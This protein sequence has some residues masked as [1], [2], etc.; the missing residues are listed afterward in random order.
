MNEQE[1][2]KYLGADDYGVQFLGSIPIDIN[3]RIF[4]DKGEAIVIEK[5]GC[6]VTKVFK[7]IVDLIEIH[8]QDST[9]KN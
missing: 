5:P 7:S 8:Y 3:T 9:I 6:E 2:K 1:R 4:S